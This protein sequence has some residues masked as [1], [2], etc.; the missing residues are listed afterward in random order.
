[1]WFAAVNLRVSFSY[2]VLSRS[3]CPKS[4]GSSVPNP[5]VFPSIPEASHRLK[6]IAHLNVLL[7]GHVLLSVKT[8]PFMVCANTFS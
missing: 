7:T 4:V 5:L 2:E 6:I 8:D 1:M 3:V